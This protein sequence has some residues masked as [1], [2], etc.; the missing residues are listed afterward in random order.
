MFIISFVIAFLIIAKAFLVPFI[1]AILLSFLLF[2]ISDF[3]HRKGLPFG[4]SI[5]LSILVGLTVIAL[6]ILFFYYQ[7]MN[8][9]DDGPQLKVQLASK[10]NDIQQFV[11]TK[12]R[13]PTWEQN[14][15]LND[16]S[17]DFLN[18]S[19]KYI[20]GVFSFTGSFL[21]GL[22][23]MPIY[24][25]F[26]TF[27]KDK[28]KTFIIKV[29]AQ[30]KK[31][32]VLALAGK[33]AKVSQ[34]YIQGLLIDI[35]ILSVLNTIGFLI[36]GLKYAILLGVIAAILNI[37]P[38]I[39]VLIGSIFPI[40][41][42]I[43]TKDSMWSAVGALGVCVFVQFLDNNFITPK[44]VGASVSINPLAT[45]VV[46]IIGGLM[47]GVAGMMMFIPLLGMVKIILDSFP[48]SQPYGYLIGEERKMKSMAKIPWIK[49]L[50]G[51]TESEK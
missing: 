46:L 45:L 43:L 10:L 15:W 50:T 18:S 32:Y 22:G 27:Y 6:L 2:P 12:F 8:F 29:T 21:A 23:L 20:S 9:M 17:N 4:L 1:L 24:I 16:H 11:A 3:L 31:D 40:M 39:G 26:M 33:T 7:V 14:Q 36:L 37:I 51:K 42:A 30:E 13:I 5:V 25:F 19:G 28:F 35:A 34:K 48:G 47:W 44:V 38:Y 49:G 41:M